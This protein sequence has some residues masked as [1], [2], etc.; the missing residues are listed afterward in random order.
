MTN[1]SA[2]LTQRE[3]AFWGLSAAP[4]DSLPPDFAPSNLLLTTP[5]GLRVSRRDFEKRVTRLTRALSTAGVGAGSRVALALVAGP[6]ALTYQI[7]LLRTGAT[8]VL[9]DPDVAHSG[10]VWPKHLEPTDVVTSSDPGCMRLT[11]SLIGENPRLRIIVVPPSAD[12]HWTSRIFAK[13]RTGDVIAPPPPATSVLSEAELMAAGRR[14]AKRKGAGPATPPAPSSAAFLCPSPSGQGAFLTSANL[15]AAIGQTQSILQ[16]PLEPSDRLAIAI[17][18]TSPL[19]LTWAIGAAW[20]KGATVIPIDCSSPV[21]IAQALNRTRPTALVIAGSPLSEMALMGI[22][23]PRALSACRV[24]VCVGGLV[25]DRALTA[26][27]KLSAAELWTCWK[28]S[29]GV[30]A[31]MGRLQVGREPGLTPLPDTSVSVRDLAEPSR[32]A[33]RGERGELLVSGPQIPGTADVATEKPPGAAIPGRPTGHLG[34]IDR[35]G[36]LVVADANEDLIVSTGY[37]IYPRRVEAALLEH[38]GVCAA[39]LVGVEINQRRKSIAFVVLAGDVAH[40]AGRHPTRG[41][42]HPSPADL[43]AHLAPRV[44][45]VELPGEI[46]VRQQLPRDAFGAISKPA[47]RRELAQR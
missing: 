33:P 6:S 13:S 37:L 10:M 45:R 11:G 12:M 32:R 19:A 30:I 40:Q 9:L 17:P 8:A 24:I 3:A 23:E 29:P 39:A 5:D 43:L 41:T 31:A 15:A 14:D 20:S 28:V 46:V 4:S 25:A 34:L 18:P 42:S 36:Q 22:L 47:L 16:E 38:P 7:A 26:L 21:R 44:S 35:D 2:G 27:A 1:H